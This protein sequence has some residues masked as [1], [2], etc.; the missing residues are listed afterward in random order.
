MPIIMYDV[1][2]ILSIIKSYRCQLTPVSKWDVHGD[3]ID[4]HVCIKFA[5]Y[6]ND[7]F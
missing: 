3:L 7:A 2:S 4:V 6:E 5:G 1:E